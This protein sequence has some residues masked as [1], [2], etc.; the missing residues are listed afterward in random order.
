MQRLAQNIQKLPLPTPSSAASEKYSG[1]LVKQICYANGAKCDFEAFFALHWGQYDPGS[2]SAKQAQGR[3]LAT[4]TRMQTCYM[5]RR[6]LSIQEKE[7]EAVA[8]A[9]VEPQRDFEG[10]CSGCRVM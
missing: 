10:T 5:S 1:S 9:P 6:N 4:R 2:G 8:P 3:Q 7:P